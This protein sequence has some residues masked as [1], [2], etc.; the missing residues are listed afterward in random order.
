MFFGLEPIA[1]NKMWPNIAWKMDEDCK[2]IDYL[3]K[4]VIVN[5]IAKS[6]IIYLRKLVIDMGYGCDIE[7]SEG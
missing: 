1:S 5:R 2:I 4:L 6:A 7:L 3:P